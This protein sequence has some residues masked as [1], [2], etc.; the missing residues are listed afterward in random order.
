MV[1]LVV[2]AQMLM[3][4]LQPLVRRLAARRWWGIVR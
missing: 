1:L 2:G 4:L 3:A